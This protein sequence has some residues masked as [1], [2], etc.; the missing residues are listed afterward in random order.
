[1]LLDPP[2]RR[3][4]RE[5][6]VVTFFGAAGGVT[7][8]KDVRLGELAPLKPRNAVVDELSTLFE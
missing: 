6:H 5:H 2:I 8:A 1:M 3:V 4:P 7:A